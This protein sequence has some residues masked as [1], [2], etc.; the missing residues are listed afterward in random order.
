M[1]ETSD[2]GKN[3]KNITIKKVGERAVTQ[4]AKKRQKLSPINVPIQVG[5]DE[6][7][8]NQ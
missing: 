3:V 8:N 6:F 5:F 7:N 1:I 2:T 4:V